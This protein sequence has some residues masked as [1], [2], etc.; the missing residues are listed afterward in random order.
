MM[1]SKERVMTT[2]NHKE[3]DRVPMWCG[4]SPEFWEKA[5]RELKLDDE[6]LRLRFHDDF[7]RVSAVYTGPSELKHKDSVYLTPFGIERHGQGYGQPYE[8][9]LANATLD[10]IHAYPW[11]DPKWNDISG[12]V[13][14]TKKFNNQYAILGGDFGL[15]FGMI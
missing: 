2:F 5:K 3:P 10:Q 4:A 7:R 6:A 1:T 8:H 11:P 9:P 13:N 14:A 12:I 15:P